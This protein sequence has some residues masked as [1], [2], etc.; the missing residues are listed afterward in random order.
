MAGD[1]KDWQDPH[2]DFQRVIRRMLFIQ[3]SAQNGTWD[4]PLLT[5]SIPRRIVN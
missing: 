4:I 3:I 2:W 1:L 5:I